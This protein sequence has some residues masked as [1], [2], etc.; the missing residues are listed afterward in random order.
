[1]VSDIHCAV[2]CSAVQVRSCRSRK[3]STRVVRYCEKKL[4]TYLRN[5]ET[6]NVSLGFYENFTLGVSEC[7]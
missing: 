2:Q 5:V 6:I 3:A 7:F 1:M 4:F